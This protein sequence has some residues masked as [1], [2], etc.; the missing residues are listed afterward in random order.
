MEEHQVD[1]VAVG[2][3]AG[4]VQAPAVGG[5]LAADADALDR[6][7]QVRRG[8]SRPLGSGVGS[9]MSGRS[10]S[11]RIGFRMRHWL[12]ASVATVSVRAWWMRSP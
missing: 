4:E 5:E 1:Q 12:S 10:A 11:A 6:E 9:G 3:G 8:R 2:V 7:F